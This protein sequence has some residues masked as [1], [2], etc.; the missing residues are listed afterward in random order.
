MT[1]L[2]IRPLPPG[3]SKNLDL[4][5]REYLTPSEVRRMIAQ[6]SSVGR[7]PERNSA[8]ILLL[9]RHGLRVS[10][11]T[12]LKWSQ[13]DFS[14]K[15]ISIQRLK[16]GGLSIHPLWP[17]EIKALKAL[18]KMR[19]QAE[20]TSGKKEVSDHV[21]LT[22]RGTPLTASAIQKIV[23]TA[24]RLSGIHFPTHPH[25][26][27]HACGYYLASRGTDTR[28]IQEYLGHRNIQNTVIYTA[29]SGE[30]FKSFWKD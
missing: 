4:R 11:A 12:L 13:I 28:A 29:L 24:G 7:Y 15:Q 22:E 26:L 1:T 17:P 3:R 18:F 16:R 10:E 30:R 5:P 6:I 25:M 14:E 9:Y 23:R 8:L 21:F 27:R 20:K 2:P 19:S